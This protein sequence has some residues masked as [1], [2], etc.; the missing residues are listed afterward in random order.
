MYWRLDDTRR[1]TSPNY[2]Q[3][4]SNWRGIPDQID[5]VLLWGHNWQTYF[6]KG[7]KYYKY[8]DYEDVVQH[9]EYISAGWS[10]VPDNIDAAFTHSDYKTYFFKG[11]FVY[12][13]DNTADRVA[14]GYPKNITDVFPGLPNELDTAFRW[15]YDT[16][17]YFFKG[18]EFWYWDGN[19]GKAIGPYNIKDN[20]KNHCFEIGR[21]SCRERV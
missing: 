16:I 4:I 12:Q 3:G 17:S 15:Y 10:G 6:F 2:P 5:D 8:K 13:F 1:Q 9:I 11:N 20:W 21:A 14:S 19:V 18:L 7:D